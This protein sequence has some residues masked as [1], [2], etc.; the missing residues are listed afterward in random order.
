MRARLLGSALAVVVSFAIAWLLLVLVVR[1]SNE[2]DWERDQERLATAELD[3]DRV[4]IRN[5]R[6]FTYRSTT[7]YDPAWYDRTF[8][9]GSLDRA[10]FVVE[11][12]GSFEGAAHTFVTFGF[13]DRDFLAISIEIRKEKGEQFSALAG[14]FR[15]YEIMYVIGDERD[16]IGLRTNHRRDEVFLYPVRATTEQI[17]AMFIGMLKR[18]N[19]LAGTPEFYN[20]LVNTCT[21]NL[22]RHVNDITP[23]RIPPSP[24]ILFPGYSDR[25]A[26]D[27]GLIDTDLPFEQL[28]ERYRINDLAIE[29]ADAPD[30]SH[31]IRGV[32]GHGQMSS[33]GFDSRM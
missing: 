6:N 10:W 22:V 30:F 24:A 17:Q 20:T 8:D 2:R 7:D 25:L 23:G 15:Q 1:P 33:R 3:G 9:L 13:S 31:R 32:E 16:L 5:I 4:T 11:P 21:T 26:F 14:L 29:H 18:A 28:R 19:E 27:L 12:F